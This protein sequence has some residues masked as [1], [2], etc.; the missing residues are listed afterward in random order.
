MAIIS[1]LCIVLLVS[2]LGEVISYILPFTFPSALVSLFLMLVLLATGAIKEE[3]I[4]H[5]TAFFLS[6]MAFFFVPAGVKLVENLDAFLSSWLEILVIVVVSLLTTF[7]AAAKSVEF[8]EF[9]TER[10]LKKRGAK[11]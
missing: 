11:T 10:Y 1:E 2:L 4:E 7:L 6:N 9:L 5:V 8:V 3:R